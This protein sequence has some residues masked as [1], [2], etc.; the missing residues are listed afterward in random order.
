MA[1]ILRFGPAVS[2]APR[3]Q[4]ACGS[5]VWFR[6]APSSARHGAAAA[7]LLLLCL[8]SELKGGGEGGHADAFSFFCGGRYVSSPWCPIRAP[9]VNLATSLLS[10]L[11]TMNRA[12]LRCCA[13]VDFWDRG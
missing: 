7:L 12:Y 5:H 11:R 10:R 4:S 13:N 9:G 2:R 8:F 1:K 3:F 6:R